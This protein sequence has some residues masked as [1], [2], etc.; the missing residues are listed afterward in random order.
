MSDEN[1]N[2]SAGG[3]YCKEP[4]IAKGVKTIRDYVRL[5]PL[6]PGVYRM[7]AIDGEV[8]YVGKAKELKKRVSSYTHFEKLPQRL[9]RM[10][11]LTSQMEFITTHTEAEALLLEANLIKKLKPRYNILLRDDKSFPHIQIDQEHDFPQVLKHR[12]AQKRKGLYFGPFPSAGDV[13]RTLSILQRV[14]LLRNCSDNVFANRSRPCLQYHIKRCTAPC[15]GYV[16][17]KDYAYQVKGAQD[18]MEGKSDAVRKRLTKA[19]Q[20]ASVDEDYERAA[21]LR[22]RIKALASVQARYDV[23]SDIGNA[24]V[25][26]LYNHQGVSCIQVFFYRSGRNLGN[27][28]YFPRHG[29]D[30]EPSAVLAAF[31]AQFYQS[32]PVPRQVVVNVPLEDAELL[33]LALSKKDGHSVRVLIPKRGK[34]KQAVD[35]VEQNAQQALERHIAHSSTRL[36][37]RQ[38]VADLFGLEDLPSRIEVYDNSHISGTN[39]V[40]AMVVEGENGFAKNAYRTFNIKQASASDDYGMM[41]EVLTRRFKRS[42]KEGHGPGSSNWPDLLLIDGGQGQLNVCQEAL[43]ELGIFDAL[44][45]VGIAKGP[46]RDA[47]REKFFMFGR[48]EFQLPINDPVLHYLQRLRDESHRFAIGTH[49]ARRNKSIS[50]SSLDQIEGIGA[51]R[52]KALLLHYGSAKEVEGAGVEDLEKVEGIS[53]AMAQKIY[54]FFHD[55]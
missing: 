19:M 45:V 31:I 13:N 6:K 22:D 35:F 40:G 39:M 5:L 36:T 20:D 30:E 18:F 44:T 12:G 51:K 52:K 47:G 41:R 8:L 42:L 9:Q 25:L 16:D 3:G 55:T 14:F 11:S 37:L 48:E 2:K 17:K 32:K 23:N 53:R 54:N 34:F 33:Q 49:R 26:A 50:K 21:L 38:G 43:E 29:K 46:D 15:V 7:M 1:E 10:V 4:S 24:D 28:A 27:K